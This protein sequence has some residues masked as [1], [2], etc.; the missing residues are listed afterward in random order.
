MTYDVGYTKRARKQVD[1]LPANIQSAIYDAVSALEQNP[2]PPGCRKL[3]GEEAWRIRVGEYRVV[4]EIDD[5]AHTVT[6]T[7]VDHRRNVYRLLSIFI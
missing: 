6:V 7:R 5:D 2:R 4:Y 3:Q 1:K